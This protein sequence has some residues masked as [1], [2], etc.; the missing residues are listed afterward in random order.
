MNTL[1]TTGLHA[2]VTE[3]LLADHSAST[4]LYL[5]SK[6][7]YTNSLQRSLVALLCNLP[8]DRCLASHR[9]REIY[10]I[11]SFIPRVRPTK[12]RVLGRANHTEAELSD[13]LVHGPTQLVVR[14]FLSLL[15]IGIT[16]SHLEVY[17]LAHRQ[18]LADL[19]YGRRIETSE[20]N[21]LKLIKEPV[22]EPIKEPI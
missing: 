9:L 7:L 18:K 8:T 12:L 4:Q 6:T 21:V 13:V 22:K 2:D 1:D 17:P 10:S 3:L 20:L 11:N 5:C 14:Y 19:G 16:F 15:E